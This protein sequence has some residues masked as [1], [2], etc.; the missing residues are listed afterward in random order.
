MPKRMIETN[1]TEEDIKIEGSLRPQ[2]LD[3]YI[4]QSKVKETLK[5]YIEAAK[6]RGDALLRA[7]GFGE[8]HAGGHHRQ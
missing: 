3:D 1:I 7:S 4:G 6:L 2:K 5:I 8:D